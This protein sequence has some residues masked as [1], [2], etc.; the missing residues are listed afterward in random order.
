M[1]FR[2]KEEYPMQPRR[3]HGIS[4]ILEHRYPSPYRSTIST[5]CRHVVLFKH[6]FV[7]GLCVTFAIQAMQNVVVLIYGCQTL[8]NSRS[9]EA[10]GNVRS[11]S[12]R[13]P[14]EVLERILNRVV[15]YHI[16]LGS[17]TH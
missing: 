4:M 2:S 17:T 16:L 14:R 6:F 9:T 7:P 3:T 10:V 13:A 5:C 8:E 11:M 1:T 15:Y 12:E